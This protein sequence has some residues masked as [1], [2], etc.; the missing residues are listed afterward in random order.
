MT[1]SRLTRLRERDLPVFHMRVIFGMDVPRAA[2][3][4]LKSA[5]ILVYYR[6]TQYTSVRL[7]SPRELSVLY[8]WGFAHVPVYL[9][10][11]LQM[12][13][14]PCPRKRTRCWLQV[15]NNGRCPSTLVVLATEYVPYTSGA[16]LKVHG[17]I[18]RSAKDYARSWHW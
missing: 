5:P 7:R 3:A 9:G 17:D 1:S 11:E 6:S 16:R 14:T 8:W 13:T 2:D 18:T 12:Y 4:T 10:Q 15:P